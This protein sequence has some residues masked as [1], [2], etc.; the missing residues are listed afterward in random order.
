MVLSAATPEVNGD[1]FVEYKRDEAL[2]W[3][4]WYYVFGVLWIVQFVFACHQV[5]IAGAVGTWYFTRDKSKLGWPIAAATKRLIRYR[6][7]IDCLSNGLG[8]PAPGIVTTT[9]PG[10]PHCLSKNEPCAVIFSHISSRFTGEMALYLFCVPPF[11]IFGL[12]FVNCQ[13]F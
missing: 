6:K 5:V 10:L 1:G 11:V 3:W 9:L 13:I 2:M 12:N 8:C 7:L 4:R